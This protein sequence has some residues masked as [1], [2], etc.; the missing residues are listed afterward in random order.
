[1]R[2]VTNRWF[3][4]CGCTGKRSARTALALMAST[5]SSA[6]RRQTRTMVK[7]EDFAR[8]SSKCYRS[9]SPSAAQIAAGGAGGGNVVAVDRR[10][11]PARRR[12]VFQAPAGGSSMTGPTSVANWTGSP[13]ASSASA[14]PA[15]RGRCRR[16]RPAGFQNAQ[17]GTAL[18]GAVEPE[19]SIG[20]TCSGGAE[21][22]TIMAFCQPPVS[23]TRRAVGNR[24]RAPGQAAL[25]GRA[26]SVEPVITPPMRGSAVSAPPFRPA[27]QQL[28]GGGGDA[29]SAHRP[30]GRSRGLLGGFGSSPGLPAAGRR[31]FAD[32][33][34]QGKFQGLMQATGPGPAG[35][36]RSAC[37]DL[38]VVAAEIDRLA[39]FAN[40]VPK[41]CRLRGRGLINRCARF[42]RASAQRI[43]G[44]RP[45]GGRRACRASAKARG[46]DRR[47]DVGQ[48]GSA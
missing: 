2:Q 31:D 44:S 21:E 3:R 20:T 34:G 29:G 8:S 46:G 10:P 7:T 12:C 26:T 45:G 24:Q 1:M 25:M 36:R 11:A 27:G 41:S 40:G 42:R 32:E 22:S 48:G 43:T 38:G 9:R 17:G 14:A 6:G 35:A 28:Q 47:L 4:R 19:A 37:G 39:D 18:A 5:R 23:A 16:C 33:D 30:G 13:M 15:G